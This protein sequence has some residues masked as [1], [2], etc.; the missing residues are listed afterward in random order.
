MLLIAWE[1]SWVLG[2]K[3]KYEKYKSQVKVSVKT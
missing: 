2:L 3:T 1:T